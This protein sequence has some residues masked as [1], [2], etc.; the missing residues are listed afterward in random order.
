MGAW[1]P[2]PVIA[3]K[4]R[5]LWLS[6]MRL[7]IQNAGFRRRGRPKRGAFSMFDR[8][9]EDIA[10]IRDRDPAARSALEVMLLYNGY[11]A[12]RSHRRANWCYRHNLKFLAR[13]ISQRCAPHQHRDPSRR[14][15]RPAAVHRSRYRCGHRGNHRHWRRLH[16][17]SGVTF[18]RHGKRYW[19]AAS[20]ARQSRDG[21]LRRQSAR[22]YRDR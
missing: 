14:H 9:K 6:L 22:A 12:V 1:F 11:K 15:H 18:G 19:K 2:E 20:D 16:H 7:S 21:G 4:G 10:C 13:W 17:L 3:Y 5:R 8:M